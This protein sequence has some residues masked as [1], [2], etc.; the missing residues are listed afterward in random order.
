M[1]NKYVMKVMKKINGYK[2]MVLSLYLVPFLN[3]A[4]EKHLVPIDNH[5]AIAPL[6]NA[7]FYERYKD[8]L[9]GDSS[10]R[11]SL[12]VTVVPSFHPVY[13]I[14]FSR[15]KI[16]IR[17]AGRSEENYEDVIVE[18]KEIRPSK[19]LYD[20]LSELFYYALLQTKVDTTFRIGLDGARY[21]LSSFAPFKQRITGM[22]W[23]PRPKSDMDELTKIISRI[24]YLE[25]KKEA[26]SELHDAAVAL[27]KR[28]K[29]Q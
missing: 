10:E 11:P 2:K 12:K 1:K 7:S 27:L 25:E 29:N 21:Y 5:P 16:K 14:A 6:Y 23:S 28:L 18:T 22:L 9:Y 13:T 17:K 20:S 4:Q 26:E 15:Y 8:V 24:Y 3:L 19:E